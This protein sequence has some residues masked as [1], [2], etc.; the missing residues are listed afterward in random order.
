[1]FESPT[2]NLVQELS[3]A[4]EFTV[5]E[6]HLKLLRRAYVAWDFGEG[7]GAPA[8]NPKKP[9][10]TSLLPGHMS[11][12]LRG[13]RSLSCVVCQSFSLSCG[14][15]EATGSW[16]PAAPPPGMHGPNSCR[17]GAADGTM[18]PWRAATG[19]RAVGH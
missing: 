18:L 19:V 15:N 1:M 8:I 5:T 9:C 14:Q 16:P 2:W 3:S 7:Y 17:P 12:G 13:C 6:E 11:S 4:R 10:R